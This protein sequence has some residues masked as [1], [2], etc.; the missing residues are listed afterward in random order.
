MILTEETKIKLVRYCVYQERSHTEVMV[1][2]RSW[3]YDEDEA[4]HYIPWLLEEDYLNESRFAS[5]FV[6][7]KHNQKKWGKY[8]ILAAL[9]QHDISEYTAN[10]ALEE[11]QPQYMETLQKLA[12]T[13]WAALGS[14]TDYETRVKVYKYLFGKGYE[15]ERINEILDPLF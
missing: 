10:K 2:L 6:R 14:K 8:K 1:K 3:G 11:I 4:M 13:K 12:M 9:K 15:N 7:G 5:A